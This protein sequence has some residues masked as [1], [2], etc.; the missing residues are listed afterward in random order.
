MIKKIKQFIALTAM[1]IVTTTTAETL[2]IC[3]SGLCENLENS[4]EVCAGRQEALTPLVVDPTSSCMC[5]CAAILVNSNETLSLIA[6]KRTVKVLPH[7]QVEA[8]LSYLHGYEKVTKPYNYSAPTG[9]VILDAVFEKT[10]Q[11]GDAGLIFLNKHQNGFDLLS[12]DDIKG[13]YD[14]TIAYLHQQDLP[15]Y[16]Q[17]RLTRKIEKKRRAHRKAL[18]KANIGFSAIDYAVYAQGAGYYRWQPAKIKGYLKVTELYVGNDARSLQNALIH[19]VDQEVV[20][21]QQQ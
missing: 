11:N 7:I 4:Q 20:A 8:P 15:K 3:Q 10:Y 17:T 9:W 1:I 2:P 14:A 6:Q 19:Y 13:A 5:D 12:D 18:F 16:Q 21:L